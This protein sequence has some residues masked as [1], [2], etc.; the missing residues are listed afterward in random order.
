MRKHSRYALLALHITSLGFMVL[1]WVLPIISIDIFADV[2]IIGKYY[3]LQE[4]RSVLG[5]LEKLFKNG[6]WFP[7]LLILLFGILVPMA[8][9]VCIFLIL[10]QHKLSEKIRYF[11]G[12]ISKWAMAD[13]FAMGIL[14]AFLAA[15]SLGQTQANFHAGFYC[16]AAYCILSNLVAQLVSTKN[17]LDF[18]N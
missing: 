3:F 14:I 11:V 9:T 7:A 12:A 18:F 1:G 16:F 13:V 4:T 5:T 15:N 8:K 10:A 6:N 17:A 2:P